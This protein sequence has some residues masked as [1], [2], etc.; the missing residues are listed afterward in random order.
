MS[1]RPLAAFCAAFG[2]LLLTVGAAAAAPPPTDEPVAETAPT[3][4]TV[5]AGQQIPVDTGP[6]QQPFPLEAAPAVT[7]PLISVPEGCAVPDPP[8]AVFEGKLIANSAAAA[9]Y[10]VLHLR[11]GSLSGQMQGNLVDVYYA[12]KETRFLDVGTTYLV[13]V[14]PDLEQDLLTSKVVDPAPDFAGDAIIGQDD[15]DQDCPAPKDAVRT[16]Q[17]NG[18]SVDSGVLTPLTNARV[19]ILRALV[20][21]AAI[22]FA[23]LVILAIVKHLVVATGRSLG[24]LFTER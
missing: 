13:G 17:R 10:E 14:R 5:L 24:S 18:E 3:P 8:T 7:A 11:A 1:P 2:A 19:G 16:V 9:R 23:V 22:A 21:P 12:S 15:T 4:T 20:V 6:A